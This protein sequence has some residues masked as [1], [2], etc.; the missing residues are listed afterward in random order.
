M[1]CMSRLRRA[2]RA[3]DGGDYGDDRREHG[4]LY[5]GEQLDVGGDGRR[6]QEVLAGSHHSKGRRIQPLH[7]LGL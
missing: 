1:I 4:G 7:R 5:R 3:V 6:V 2:V